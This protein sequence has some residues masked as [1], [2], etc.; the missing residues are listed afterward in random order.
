MTKVYFFF[1][2]LDESGVPMLF[3]R[4]SRWVA[5]HYKNELECYVVDYEN[6]AMARNLTSEDVV[7][8]YPYCDNVDCCIGDD[9]IVIFQSFNVSFWPRNLKLSAKTILFWWTLH[10]RCLAPALIP[11]PLA[12]LTYKYHWL[13]KTIATFYYS[14]MHGFA[15]LMDDMMAHGSLYFMD[16]TTFNMSIKHL[17]MK[18]RTISDF[19]QLPAQ[20]YNGDLK[21]FKTEKELEKCVNICWL[22][23]LCNEKTPVLKLAIRRLS[24]FALQKKQNIKFYVLGYGNHQEEIDILGQ[25]VHNDY[26]NQ[27]KATPIHFKE[28]DSFLLNNIDLMIATGTSALEAAKLGVPTIAVD[29]SFTSAEIKGDYVFKMIS[30]RINY[31][32]GH[33]ITEAD[34]KEGNTSLEKIMDYLINH[35]E[36][37]SKESRSHFVRYHSMTSVGEKFVGLLKHSF[38]TFDKIDPKMTKPLWTWQ[39][40]VKMRQRVIGKK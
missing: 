18:T 34:C 25:E 14:F 22:G 12:E 31:D 9:S 32:L 5:A 8:L 17:P 37:F 7:K 3:L 35:F 38:F 13:Y 23:R 40:W 10:E 15:K 20:D 33:D 1:P 26:Y 11:F 2:Y 30:E 29:D 21:K 36:D 28:I 6:G 39:I 4:M 19:L 16:I 27:L 24:K